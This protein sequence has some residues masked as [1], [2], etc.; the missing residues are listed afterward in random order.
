MIF[1]T[2]LLLLLASLI[3]LGTA[4][5]ILTQFITYYYKSTLFVIYSIT[6]E[7]SIILFLLALVIHKIYGLK[8]RFLP[9]KG[10]KIIGIIGI[11][12]TLN[13]ITGM[14]S[15]H[16]QRTPTFIQAILFGLSI[17]VSVIST[18]YI[19]KKDVRYEKKYIIPSMIFLALS[20]IIPITNMIID[21]KFTYLTFM[22]IIIFTLNIALR[23]L[24]NIYQEKFL[25]INK[26][27]DMHIELLKIYA[28]MYSNLCRI[29]LLLLCL[30]IDY[31]LKPN[32]SVFVNL[33]DGLINLFTN[34]RDGLLLHF[35]GI[36]A[37][38][39]FIVSI[40]VNKIS[41]NYNMML[42]LMMSPLGSLFFVIFNEFNFGVKFNW[43][44]IL[45]TLI[46]TILSIVLWIIGEKKGH[47]HK[48][49]DA[50]KIIEM[51]DIELETKN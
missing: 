7:S 2:K 41:T 45:S 19:L 13:V 50:N 6:I 36:F 25:M 31:I 48:L 39:M 33:F 15:S 11:I 44:I 22:W 43:Y 23:G 28:I 4:Q 40:T 21:V 46:C 51:N 29:P 38:A 8:L 3:L 24:Y 16:P 5:F 9:P 37:V 1:N 49:D 10:K 20:I 18:K 47:Y 34:P 30:P 26:D 35:C 42:T 17:V 32:E 27:S 14:Y 12:S